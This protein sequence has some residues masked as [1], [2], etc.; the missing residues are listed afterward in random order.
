MFA[1]YIKT[2]RKSDKKGFCRILKTYD[3]L[4]MC[5]YHNWEQH[6]ANWKYYRST[7]L[8]AI[9]I[10]TSISSVGSLL[11]LSTICKKVRIVDFK[12]IVLNIANVG[13][14]Q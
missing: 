14:W 8:I 6:T 2:W 1:N 5:D 7:L 10:L 9:E 3:L 4:K 13:S 11:L 12:W